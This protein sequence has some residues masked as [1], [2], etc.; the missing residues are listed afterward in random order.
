MRETHGGSPTATGTRLPEILPLERPKA[1]SMGFP[2]SKMLLFIQFRGGWHDDKCWFSRPLAP[3]TGALPPEMHRDIMEVYRTTEDFSI[4]SRPVRKQVLEGGRLVNPRD[5]GSLGM[6]LLFA[7]PKKIS[8]PHS[9]E[10]FA[11]HR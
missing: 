11:A 7:L 1:L 3:R 9:A 4:L 2:F 6:Q 5:A 10:R 8:P